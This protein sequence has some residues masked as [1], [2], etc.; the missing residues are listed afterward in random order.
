[1]TI[2][3]IVSI[4]MHPERGEIAIGPDTHSDVLLEL[5]RI[6]RRSAAG[7]PAP[8]DAF[9]MLMAINAAM[10]AQA[11]MPVFKSVRAT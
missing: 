7:R 6:A 5:R 10:A 4:Y 8:R 2:D 3:P 11:P 9:A 1:M